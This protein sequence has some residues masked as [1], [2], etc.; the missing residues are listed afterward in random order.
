MEKYYRLEIKAPYESYDLI[1]GML[2]LD[3][4]FGWEEQSLCTGETVF[5]LYCE[6]EKTLRQ[7][8]EKAKALNPDVEIIKGEAEKTD[9]LAAW[10]EFFTP[11]QCGANFVILPPWLAGDV[12]GGRHKIL[13]EPKC[14]FGTGHHATTAICV[15]A[16]DSLLAG[17]FIRPGQTFL[18]LGCGSGVLGIAACVAGLKGIGLDIDPLAIANAR[19]NRE[20]NKIN[21]LELKQ[22]SIE[23][24]QG[25][26]FDLIMSNILARPLMEM[27]PRIC[28]CLKPASSL[29]LSGI[30]EIQADAVEEAFR[31]CGLPEARK[32]ARD[33]WVALVW[34]GAGAC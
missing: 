6:D 32:L 20:L 9:W 29:A 15:E 34:T 21:D 12:Y 30:L 19:E 22:G 11:V 24:A 31:N 18:D 25:K 33:E 14:A 8:G 5:R 1:A 3:A 26:K 27:A 23:L 16:L 7:I 13:I 4:S 28:A 2:A 17:G 10:K